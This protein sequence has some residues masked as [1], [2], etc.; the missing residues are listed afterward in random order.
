MDAERT[1]AQLR[2]WLSAGWSETAEGID[3]SV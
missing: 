3:V 1:S 2:P